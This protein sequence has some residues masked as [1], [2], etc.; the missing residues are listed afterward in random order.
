VLRKRCSW[1]TPCFIK[2]LII[3]ELD[4]K[5]VSIAFPADADP[6]IRQKVDFIGWAGYF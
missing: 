3:V 4:V 2:N 5:A 6:A 1:L